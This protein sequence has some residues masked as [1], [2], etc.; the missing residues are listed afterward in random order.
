MAKKELTTAETE[1]AKLKKIL[2][3]IPTITR[4]QL[5]AADGLVINGAWMKG[6]LQFLRAAIDEKGPVEAYQ[7]GANQS[8]FKQSVEVQIYNVMIKNYQAVMNKL[9][10]MIPAVEVQERDELMD[11]IQERGRYSNEPEKKL[12]V[13]KK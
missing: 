9:L 11:F 10:Q 6:Q 12:S 8:G 7:N 1:A 5:T 3:K 2:H 13:V 4:D